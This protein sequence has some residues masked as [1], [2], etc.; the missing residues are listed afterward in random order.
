MTGLALIIQYHLNPRNKHQK[1][2]IVSSKS[3]SNGISRELC[4]VY[5]IIQSNTHP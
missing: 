4:Y 5:V 2:R 3:I 1:S